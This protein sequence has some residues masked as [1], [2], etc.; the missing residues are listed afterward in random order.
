MQPHRVACDLHHLTDILYS[1]KF[2]FGVKA[3]EHHS[4]ILV[5]SEFAA[6]PHK[7]FELI[8]LMPGIILHDK[9]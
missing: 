8:F 3:I 2:L 7:Q 6:Q 9:I 1:L 5:T 4:I